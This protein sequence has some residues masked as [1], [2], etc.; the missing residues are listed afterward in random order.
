V[1]YRD[2]T[3]AA[4]RRFEM[5]RERALE[6]D[7]RLPVGAFAA[8]H[9]GVRR[10]LLRERRRCEELGGHGEAADAW[11]EH[12]DRLVELFGSAPE[13]GDTMQEIVA[14]LLCLRPPSRVSQ[15]VAQRHAT[16]LA[17][18]ARAV[19][20]D[21]RITFV[22]GSIMTARLGHAGFPVA[23]VAERRRASFDVSV[24]TC[25]ARR[26][27]MLTAAVSGHL[28][29]LWQQG[30]S[31]DDAFTATF[32]IDAA[33]HGERAL[34]AEAMS[35]LLT[36]ARMGATPGL[37]IGDGAVALSWS[38]RNGHDA[39]ATSLEALS[40]L[41]EGLPRAETLSPTPSKRRRPRRWPAPARRSG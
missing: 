29:R 11:R 38:H 4:R 13:R 24:A 19:A 26:A 3:Q 23:I 30:T 31:L 34:N 39:L 1:G 10:R 16:R 37:D 35:A 20:A 5:E 36:L 9:A 22:R 7:D 27:P 32:D 17:H 33:P 14:A 21:A 18:L 41:R 2:A 12:R 40:A 8:L 28:S 15:L 25:A 6:L